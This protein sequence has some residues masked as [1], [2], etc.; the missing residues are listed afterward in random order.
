MQDS[1]AIYCS[2]KSL[3]EHRAISAGAAAERV[4]GCERA[5]ERCSPRSGSAGPRDIR[6]G[7]AA[8]RVAQA[9]CFSAA[10]LHVLG[11]TVRVH[12]RLARQLRRLV[13]A[14]IRLAAALGGGFGPCCRCG[15]R[16][17]PPRG[18]RARAG[19][20]QQRRRPCRRAAL[21]GREFK[22]GRA[23]CGICGRSPLTE[24]QGV[25]PSPS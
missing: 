13:H 12:A 24:R 15:R 2:G 23:V 9:C 25:S 3:R 16:A 22:G 8:S 18:L 21:T 7:C 4:R 11:E 10:P 14:A 6:R 19:D 17:D 1:M 5:G 20:A